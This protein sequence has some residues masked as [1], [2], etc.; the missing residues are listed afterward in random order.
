MCRLDALSA[1][2]LLKAHGFFETLNSVALCV[3]ELYISLRDLENRETLLQGLRD[4]EKKATIKLLGPLAR[5][6]MR[7][8]DGRYSL[9]LSNRYQRSGL[10]EWP[11]MTRIQW[12][13]LV[14]FPPSLLGK[15]LLAHLSFSAQ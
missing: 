6:E 3:A 8:P 2:K 13:A 4:E 7:R 10:D 14:C 5:L 1:R 9:D 15:V 11:G 12:F